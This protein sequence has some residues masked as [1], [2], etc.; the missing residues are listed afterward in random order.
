[1]LKSRVIRRLTPT[2]QVLDTATKESSPRTLAL[3][4]DCEF[5]FLLLLP[6]SQV[7]DV[8]RRSFVRRDKEGI[9]EP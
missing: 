4:D 1:M 9:S 2:L 7:S 8:I 3:V 5:V 6:S